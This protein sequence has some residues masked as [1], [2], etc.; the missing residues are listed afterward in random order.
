MTIFGLLWGHFWPKNKKNKVFSV[1]T[2]KNFSIWN[3]NVAPKKVTFFGPRHPPWPPTPPWH[4]PGAR[5]GQKWPK[6][7]PSSP[8]MIVNAK[9]AISGGSKISTYFFTRNVPVVMIM[10]SFWS[11]NLVITSTY[12]PFFF[13]LQDT[14][15]FT[16]MVSKGLN[17]SWVNIG[18]KPSVYNIWAF[19]FWRNGGTKI[20]IFQETCSRNIRRHNRQGCWGDFFAR[21][22]CEETCFGANVT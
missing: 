19:S 9:K 3:Q 5:G 16:G 13:T 2:I 6:C 1:H 4:P 18:L 8:M 10:I 11:E 22:F 12:P 21:R 17:R 7:I 20:A 14:R 15:L